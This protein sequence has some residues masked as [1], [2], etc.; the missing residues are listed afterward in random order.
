MAS[1]NYFS[2]ALEG[3]VTLSAYLRQTG[4]KQNF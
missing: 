4:R 3:F 1:L 2:K